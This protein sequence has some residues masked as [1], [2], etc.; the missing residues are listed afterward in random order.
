MSTLISQLIMEKETQNQ[1]F[2]SN[3][4]PSNLLIFF[5][6][7]YYDHF[8][9]YWL[10]TILIAHQYFPILMEFLQISMCNVYDTLRY[11]TTCVTSSCIFIVYKTNKQQMI[12]PHILHSKQNRKN[13]V[14]FPG[15]SLYTKEKFVLKSLWKN[16]LAY[17]IGSQ[18]GY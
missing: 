5:I 18:Y 7:S 14:Q 15:L 6:P 4:K 1:N 3:S 17:L 16:S 11:F 2:N 13:L 9:V 10:W 8:T 12:M